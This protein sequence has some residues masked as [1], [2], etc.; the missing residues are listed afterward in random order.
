MIFIQPCF[1]VKSADISEILSMTPSSTFY[2]DA[3]GELNDKSMEMPEEVAVF[4]SHI[5]VI[6]ARRRSGSR[7]KKIIRKNC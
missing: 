5:I 3:N 4:I 7:I 2:L 6:L 1:P